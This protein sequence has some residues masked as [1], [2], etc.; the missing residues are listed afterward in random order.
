MQKKERIRA[1][2]HR[3]NENIDIRNINNNDNNVNI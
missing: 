3:N 1:V 2:L